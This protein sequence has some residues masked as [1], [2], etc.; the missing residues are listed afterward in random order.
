MR[1]SELDSRIRQL[2]NGVDFLQHQLTLMQNRRRELQGMTVK[3]EPLR[4]KL[5]AKNRIEINR[6]IDTICL[7]KTELW[8]L[9]EQ[10]LPRM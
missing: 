9:K 5:L 3:N 2:E 10:K 7:K 4:I 8:G 6:M 1:E